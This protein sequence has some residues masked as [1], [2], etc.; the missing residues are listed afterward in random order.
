MDQELCEYV[1]ARDYGV[2]QLSGKLGEVLHHI[3]YR[4]KGGLN[5][6]NN[7]ILLSSDEH[8]KEHN[9]TARSIN[10]YYDRVSKNEK[11]FRSRIV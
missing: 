10:L 1:R 6:A 5:T 2:C 3:R 8:Y 4:S 9:V 11:R 7:L